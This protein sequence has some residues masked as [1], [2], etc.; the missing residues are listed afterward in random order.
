[1]L[2]KIEITAILKRRKLKG[3]KKKK[4]LKASTTRQK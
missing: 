2:A 3:Q 1:M 4:S